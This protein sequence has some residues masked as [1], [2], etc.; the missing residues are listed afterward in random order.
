MNN[1]ILIQAIIVALVA[2]IFSWTIVKNGVK[3]PTG[4]S[5]SYVNCSTVIYEHNEHSF[6]YSTL[7]PNG[8]INIISFEKNTIWPPATSFILAII[9]RTGIGLH[10][11]AIIFVLFFTFTT[12]FFSVIFSNLVTNSEIVSIVI[13]LLFSFS[14]NFFYWIG[15]SVMSEGLFITS[16]LIS[17][18][19]L[20]RHLSDINESKMINL[21][22]IGMTVGFSYLIKSVAPAFIFSC[23]LLVFLNYK[24]FKDKL[25]SSFIFVIGVLIPSLPWLLR[26]LHL[27]TI[28]SAG[29]GPNKYAIL[30]SILNLI[31]LFIPKYGSYFESKITL[32][33]AL[34]FIVS[35]LTIITLPIIRKSLIKNALNKTFSLIIGENK[36][37]FILIYLVV[38]INVLLFSMYVLPLAINIET[39]Y[40]MVLF[41]FTVPFFYSIS[42]LFYK[43]YEVK[44]N[45]FIKAI[46]VFLAALIFFSNI[47]EIYRNNK[48][49]WITLNTDVDR[50]IVRSELSTIIKSDKNIRFMSN[51]AIEFEIKTGLTSWPISD[52]NDLIL[53][54]YVELPYLNDEMN[55]SKIK[56][57]IPPDY[58]H[59]LTYKNIKLYFKEDE[60]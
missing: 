7:K 48:K 18:I 28:G 12:I 10:Y 20:I 46:F 22:L 4:D 59:R 13:G 5:M 11:S 60:Y 39:R 40:W 57:E 54:C 21:F 8:N 47:S 50:E 14:W 37:K 31:R 15:V 53:N 43:E 32:L 26:N 30:E 3:I 27:N 33:F 16:T 24:T 41:P 36:F 25:I 1:K 19:L 49:D 55:L 9:Q 42:M 52:Y 6:V 35:L 23:F 45:Y 2:T 29:T 34:I 58:R 56:T 51:K 17:A 44:H 38:F